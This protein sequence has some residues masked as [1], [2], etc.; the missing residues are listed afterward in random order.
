MQLFFMARL[1]Y[2]W[3][4]KFAEPGL[5]GLIINKL[6]MNLHGILTIIF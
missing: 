6:E 5:E 1:Q 3:N 2:E 4:R